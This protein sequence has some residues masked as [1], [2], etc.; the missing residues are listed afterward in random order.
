MDGDALEAEAWAYLAVRSLK[1]LPIT[2]PGTTGVPRPLT[3]GVLANAEI[4]AQLGL[5]VCSAIQRRKSSEPPVD[6]QHEE[7]GVGVGVQLARLGD[8]PVGQRRA[9]LDQHRRLGPALALALPDVDGSHAGEDVDTGGKPAIDQRAAD[10]LRL[11]GRGEG[12]VDQNGLVVCVQLSEPPHRGDQTPG[13]PAT[14]RTMTKPSAKVRENRL[15]RQRRAGGARGPGAPRQRLRQRRAQDGRRHR[16]ARRRRADAADAAP[17]PER[18]RADLRH[19]PRLDR[20]P[21]ERLQRG[22]PARPARARR[23]QRHPSARH[24]RRRRARQACTRRSPSTRCRCS[25]R[26]IRPPSSGSPSTARCGSRS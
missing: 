7:C 8:R 19:E 12:R 15:R 22:R 24:A 10:P 17:A 4:A 2:F 14:L 11:R 9:R 16:R 23:D 21:D 13:R 18:P 6:G 1:G 5:A 20:L 25:A 3:G 26:P